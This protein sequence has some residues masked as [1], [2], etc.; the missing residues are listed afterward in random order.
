MEIN[1]DKESK[2]AKILARISILLNSRQQLIDELQR[3]GHIEPSAPYHE[4]SDIYDK[5]IVFESK[6][7][8]SLSES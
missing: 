3:Y 5:L 8:E 2:R 7:L 6:A 4:L 1:L